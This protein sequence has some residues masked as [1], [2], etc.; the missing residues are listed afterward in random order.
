MNTTNIL[1]ATN[2]TVGG[3]SSLSDADDTITVASSVIGNIDFGGGSDQL[4]GIGTATVGA[5]AATNLLI[6]GVITAGSNDITG[7]GTGTIW[8]V[9][10]LN[11]TAA[12]AGG[13][14]GIVL[15]Y[16]DAV[17]GINGIDSNVSD[18]DELAELD[19]LDVIINSGDLAIGATANLITA[20][21]N[22]TGTNA[23]DL[24]IHYGGGS[25]TTISLAWDGAE[26]AFVSGTMVDGKHWRITGHNADTLTLAATV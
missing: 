19:N 11:L 17:P 25:Q 8:L 23:I 12:Q 4:I 9:E 15:D 2:S 21:Q 13:F 26:N 3:V 16:T 20:D 7:A 6:R 22:F 18:W 14:T 10:G 1:N 24:T 5:V